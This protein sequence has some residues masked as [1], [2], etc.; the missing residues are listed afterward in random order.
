MLVWKAG[1]PFRL[2]PATKLIQFLYNHRVTQRRSKSLKPE[3]EYNL[4]LARAFLQKT[5]SPIVEP[6]P[7]Y[8]TFEQNA[9]QHQREMLS[10]TLGLALEKMD[11]CS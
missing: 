3:F 4:D 10:Q 7:P 1:I 6:T 2:A 8:L 9:V 5:H 11:F